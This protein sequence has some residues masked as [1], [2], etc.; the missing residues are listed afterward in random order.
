MDYEKND[1]LINKEMHK[2]KT[3]ALQTISLFVHS[4]DNLYIAKMLAYCFFDSLPDAI[5]IAE[6]YDLC[7]LDFLAI[8]EDF[9]NY[10]ELF[11]IEQ[12]KQFEGEYE[13]AI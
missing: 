7:K 3:I 4:E 12:E 9:E 11:L 1:E 10:K 2:Q 13:H 5:K 6:S 8:N